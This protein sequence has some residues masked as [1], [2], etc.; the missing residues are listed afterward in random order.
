MSETEDAPKIAQLMVMPK[1][2]YLPSHRKANEKIKQC[3]NL[4]LSGT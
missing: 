1:L 4:L 2:R 3:M